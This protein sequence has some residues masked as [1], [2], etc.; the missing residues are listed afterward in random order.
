MPET[1]VVV[2]NMNVNEVIRVYP[3]TVAVFNR[4]GIDACCGGAE[5]VVNAALR[6]GADP[7]A[8][9]AELK[10]VIASAS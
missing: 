1:T 6:D 3:D 2:D 4:F 10:R 9:L 7:A 8:L 5:S